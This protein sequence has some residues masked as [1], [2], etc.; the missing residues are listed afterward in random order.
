MANKIKFEDVKQDIEKN[1]WLLKSTEYLNLKTDLLVECPEGHECHV[2]YEKWRR[3]NYECPTCKNNPYAHSDNI[4]VKKTGFRILA[5]DQASITSGWAIFDDGKLI[6][7]GKW[8]SDGNKSTERIA[9]TKYWVA[10]MIDKW[11]PDQVVLEDIQ[12]QKF[13][14]GQEGV[15]TFK[16]LAH[17]QGVLKN[18]FYELGLPYKVVPPS[19]WRA[20]SE[21]KGKTRSDKKKNAQI[22]VKR[23]YDISVDNDTADAILIGHWAVHDNESNKIIE[24]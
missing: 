16:K 1:G 8:T 9:K 14:S 19:T 7:F 5:L 12:L 10:S 23:F 21:I 13:D 3:K 20:F 24:F 4:V 18:Y 15:T 2:S 22:K 11:R 17:L 6:K